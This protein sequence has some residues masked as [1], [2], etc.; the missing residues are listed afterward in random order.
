[1]GVLNWDA[2]ERISDR[3][4]AVFLMNAG[5]SLHEPH[6]LG[7]PRG[8]S[9]TAEPAR[10]ARQVWRYLDSLIPDLEVGELAGV[11]AA[12]VYPR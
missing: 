8:A 5:D 9:P 10:R 2:G 3:Y 12:L 1:V 11:Q 6:R 4:G 7:C